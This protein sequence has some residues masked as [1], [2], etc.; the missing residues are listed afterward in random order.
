VACKNKPKQTADCATVRKPQHVAHLRGGYLSVALHIGMG[1]G[2]I[3]DRE[4]I[5]H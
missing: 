4:A 1:N 5:A 2:L 3:K